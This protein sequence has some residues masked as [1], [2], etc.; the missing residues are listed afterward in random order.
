MDLRLEQLNILMNEIRLVIGNKNCP[1]WIVKRL[2]EG[3][4]KAKSLADNNTF[5]DP[6]KPEPDY[7]LRP[8]NIGEEVLSTKDGDE[9]IY[10]IIEQSDPIN[11]INLYSIKIIKG[12]KNNPPGYIVY[13]VPETLLVHIKGK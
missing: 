1:E 9:C 2:G 13:N 10:Q 6:D 3:V 12:N 5:I 4:K 7:T 8:F 11:N